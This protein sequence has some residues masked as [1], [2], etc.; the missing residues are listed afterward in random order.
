[1]DIITAQQARDMTR[2]HIPYGL[3]NT[4]IYTMGKIKEAANHGMNFVEFRKDTTPQCYLESISSNKFKEY[5][6]SLG[7]R[8]KN[9][10]KEWR[11]YLYERVIISW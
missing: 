8:H 4:V 3:H 10:C 9:E 7:Y 5:I 2:V 1:M 6:T 11:G